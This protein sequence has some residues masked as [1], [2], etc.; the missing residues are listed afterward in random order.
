MAG[1]KEGCSDPRH[2]DH[3]CQIVYNGD[4]ERA[5]KLAEGAEYMCKQC[6]RSAKSKDN[7]CAPTKMKG[8]MMMER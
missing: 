3:M 5:A 6:G 1:I 4:F 7:L 8:F 2:K